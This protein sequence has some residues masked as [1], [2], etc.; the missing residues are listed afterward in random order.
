MVSTDRGKH[1]ILAFSA[2]MVLP[3]NLVNLAK[4]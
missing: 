2:P 1:T 4:H 3:Y